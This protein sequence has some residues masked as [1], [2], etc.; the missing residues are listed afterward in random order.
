VLALYSYR[1]EIH[2]IKLSHC[3][4]LL[5]LNQRLLGCCFILS[6]LYFFVHSLQEER[7]FALKVSSLSNVCY[8]DWHTFGIPEIRFVPLSMKNPLFFRGFL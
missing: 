3:M 1:N 5:L 7:N 4:M 6:I 8:R 2:V